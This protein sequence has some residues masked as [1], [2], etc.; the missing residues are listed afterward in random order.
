MRDKNIYSLLLIIVITAIAL[1]VDF[2]PDDMFLGRDV[3]TRQ[4]LDLQGGIQVLLSAAQE[5]VTRE[6]M[7]TAA[8]V[9]ERRVN[10]LGVGETV[11]QLSGEDRIIVEL[12]GIANPDQALEILRGTGSLEFIN[13][14]GQYLPEGQ[15]VRTTNNPDPVILQETEGV[16]PTE[17][18]TAT[19]AITP[20]VQTPPEAASGP[21]YDS[22]TSGKD[23]DTSQVAPTLSQ[24][25]AGLNEPAVSFAFTGESARSLATFTAQNVG[26]P[27]CIVLDNRVVSCPVVQSPL[28]DGSGVITTNDAED[29]DAIFAQLK[30]GALP[31]PLQVETNRTV[32]ATLGEDSVQASTRAGIIGLAVVA[33]FM[34]IYYR[35]PGVLAVIALLM[36]TAIC[37]AFYR[38]IPITLTLAGIAGFILSIGLAVDANVLIFARLKE[39]LRRKREL[40]KAIELGFDEAW[41]AIRDSSVST[42]IT[43][44]VLFLFGN[45][46]GVSIIKGFALTL[47]LGILVSL[48][49][50]I[51]ITRTL[52]RLIV[53]LGISRNRWFFGIDPD[54]PEYKP[55]EVRAG[56]RSSPA[57]GGS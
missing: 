3:H 47:G 19:D 50:A 38:L 32:S 36:Y 48:F 40:R 20:P 15:V 34:I 16:T 33:L 13:S 26:Q 37:F 35:L 43:S 24:N 44:V 8:G 7:Q 9:I 4:G 1:W 51:F 41:P 22:I 23:L 5:D 31:I 6:E 54:E 27:M 18:L 53:P 12:P 28:T 2:A 10:G 56:R 49:S 30:Y 25:Q 55:P 57:G 14:Q 39:E 21:I 45:S 17:S 42:L 52:L 46:F 29:R 11:V